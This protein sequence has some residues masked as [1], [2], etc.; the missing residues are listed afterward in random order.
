M[1]LKSENSR[2]PCK[3]SKNTF[4]IKSPPLS[5]DKSTHGLCFKIK[6]LSN[7]SQMKKRISS[8]ITEAKS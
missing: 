1:N 7:G 3:I 5:G 2:N 6:R 8:E 4:F